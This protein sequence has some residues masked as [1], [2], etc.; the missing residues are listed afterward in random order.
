MST[1]TQQVL[2]RKAQIDAEKRAQAEQRRSQHDL[3]ALSAQTH[4]ASKALHAAAMNTA[5]SSEN[6]AR[7]EQ[8]D[9]ER[10]EATLANLNAKAAHA[11]EAVEQHRIEVARHAAATGVHERSLEGVARREEEWE[12][13]RVELD[14]ELRRKSAH[15]EEIKRERM[16]MLKEKARSF[17]KPFEH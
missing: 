10:I 15:A 11:Q 5:H 9:A 14:N 4:S 16:E 1:R 8:Q 7:K 6:L 13:R 3:A 2:E 17:E 12:Q